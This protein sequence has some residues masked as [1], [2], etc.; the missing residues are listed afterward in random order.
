MSSMQR[1]RCGILRSSFGGSA[2]GTLMQYSRR[3]KD[4]LQHVQATVLARGDWTP[5]YLATGTPAG[6][7]ILRKVTTRT[8][9]NQ[10][11]EKVLI[12]L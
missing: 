2:G 7:G 12:P 10:L 9:Q 11:Y 3:P 4:N 1:S 8:R 6:E 5:E